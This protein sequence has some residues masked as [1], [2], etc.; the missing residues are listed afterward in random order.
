[1][2]S[3]TPEHTTT[4]YQPDG[5]ATLVNGKNNRKVT[6]ISAY[7]V[8]E[9]TLK[10]AGL[11]T[12]WK[13]QWQ[14]LCK[15]GYADPDPRKLFP[16]NFNK[17]IEA[18]LEQD[19]KLIIGMDA[20]EV[21]TPNSDIE[22]FYNIHDLIEVFSH[23]YPDITPPNTYQW[24]NNK[25]NYLFTTPTLI[26]AIKAVGFLLFNIPFLTDHGSIFTDFDK[27]ILLLGQVN[28]LIDWSS[29]NLITSNPKCRDRYV[30]ILNE[31]FDCNNICAR[32]EKLYTDIKH[33]NISTTTAI[34]QHEQID[35]K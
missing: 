26:P 16:H 35:K 20:N 25:I 34:E 18:W 31:V 15:C 3:C 12:C 21:D 11:K 24:S 8:Y 5:T 23:K 13:Q 28:N 9:N 33:T 7:R 29:R 22:E 2:T 10:E 14:Q 6:I 30:N 32:V 4:D 19:E 27:E 17:F 1:M